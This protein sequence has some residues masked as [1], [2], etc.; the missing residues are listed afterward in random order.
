MDWNR[1]ADILVPDE[2]VKPLDYYEALYPERDL[3]KGARVTRLAPSPTG[4]MH[5]GNLYVAIANERI[6][7]QSGGVFYLRIEDTDDK[8]KVEGAVEVIHSSLKYFGIAFDEGAELSGNYGPYYQRQRAEIYHAYAKDLIRRGLAY[9]CFCTEEELERRA[10][11]RRKT[12]SFP[13][14]TANLR[15]VA[16]F[17]RRRFLPTSRR[18]N[19]TS[20]ACVRRGTSRSNIPSATP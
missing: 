20:S 2:N 15:I 4:F 12:N 8:R 5:L 18:K 1:L 9:P 13:A 11:T 19:R 3:P 14:I 10:N 6:A 16:I 7:H 17:P